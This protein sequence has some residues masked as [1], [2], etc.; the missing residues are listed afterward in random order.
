M[1]E[2]VNQ[3]LLTSNRDYICIVTAKERNI[4]TG[5]LDKITSRLLTVSAASV[6]LHQMKG[7][8]AGLL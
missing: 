5:P 4:T 3:F 8:R 2:N 1:Q 6:V 7:S